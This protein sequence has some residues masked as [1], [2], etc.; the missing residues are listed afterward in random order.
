MQWLND[1]Q[2]GVI[3]SIPKRRMFAVP[4]GRIGANH[5]PRG[6]KRDSNPEKLNHPN[7]FSHFSQYVSLLEQPF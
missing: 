1:W 7:P 5:R 6:I 3:Q 2:T 4:T